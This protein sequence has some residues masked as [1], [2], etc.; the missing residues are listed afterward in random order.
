M[1]KLQVVKATKRLIKGYYGIIEHSLA[2]FFQGCVGIYHYS[3][4]GMMR[5][6]KK[7]NKQ[8][9]KKHKHEQQANRYIIVICW[10][11]HY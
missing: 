5:D 3:L 2:G 6:M 7:N 10:K 4:L 1:Q 9:N 8:T 11:K